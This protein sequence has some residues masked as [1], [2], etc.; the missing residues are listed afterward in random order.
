MGAF[1]LV[2]PASLDQCLGFLEAHAEDAAVLAG[3]TDLGV[4]VRWGVKAPR[5]IVWVG[6]LQELGQFDRSGGRISFGPG[7]THRE[8]AGHRDLLSAETLRKAARSVGSPQ[9]RNVATAGGNLANASPAADLYPPLLVLEA[10]IEVRSARKRSTVSVGDFVKGP[11]ATALG[12]GELIT[13]VSFQ[14][15]GRETFSDFVKIGLRNAVAIWVA[16][17]AI[18]ASL[19]RDRFATVRIACGAVAPKPKRMPRVEALLAG[20]GLTAE[21][22][23]EVEETAAGECD[24]ITDI[25]ASREYRRHV[26]GV[27]V[28]RLVETAWHNLRG[29]A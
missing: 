12:P 11:G 19:D 23:R 26:A 14:E 3:G 29:S 5:A 6:R 27:I 21:L 28:A 24:P 25:R 17:A 22:L 2:V 10:A 15:P 9:V 1:D 18:L 20:S 8:I 16:N 4:A 7:F 13:G